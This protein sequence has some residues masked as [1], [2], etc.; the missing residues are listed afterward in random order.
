MLVG[1]TGTDRDKRGQKTPRLGDPVT[2]RRQGAEGL[3][4][5]YL[6]G[7]IGVLVVKDQGLLDE[8][9]V[10][11][12]LVDVV[13]V[14][15]DVVLVLFQLVHLVLQGPRDLDGA[16]GNLLAE[17][18]AGEGEAEPPRGTLWA[19][20]FPAL[21]LMPATPAFQAAAKVPYFSDEVG[22]RAVP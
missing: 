8:L 1:Q 5:L 7:V 22:N 2:S 15:D 20:S 17:A 9:V 18:R 21:L 13:L 14:V 19:A 10:A 11:F 12:Q 16:P 4:Q 6:H 3:R